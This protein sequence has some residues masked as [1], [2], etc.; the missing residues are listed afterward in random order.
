MGC[1]GTVILVVFVIILAVVALS[2]YIITTQKR[3]GYHPANKSNQPPLSSKNLAANTTKA[4]DIQTSQSSQSPNDI[5][6]SSK[7]T[8]PKTQMSA[9][10]FAQRIVIKTDTIANLFTLKK[11][12]EQDYGVSKAQF[13]SMVQEYKDQSKLP[14]TRIPKTLTFDITKH[15]EADQDTAQSAIN[16]AV[17][18]Q[19]IDASVVQFAFRSTT[20]K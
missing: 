8:R 14:V 1:T 19:P 5:K 9:P 2:I 12:Y 7:D 6:D 16:L 10:I 11:D 20:G 15:I 17:K 13:Q 3:E 18:S 4:S